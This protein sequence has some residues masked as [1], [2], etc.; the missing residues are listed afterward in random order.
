M[1]T[2]VN[3]VDEHARVRRRI[4]NLRRPPHAISV[5]QASYLRDEYGA[6]QEQVEEVPRW[7]LW[8]MVACALAFVAVMSVLVVVKWW[9]REGS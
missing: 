1:V 7:Y 8:V 4:E 9:N 2:N 5:E 6:R 3:R